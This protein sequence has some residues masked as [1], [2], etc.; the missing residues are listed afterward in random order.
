MEADGGRENAPFN[1]W[2][3][4]RIVYGR[5]HRAHAGQDGIGRAQPREAASH[6]RAG[7]YP[8]RTALY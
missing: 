5:T 3:P 7:P 6:A 1:S 4:E 8:S 2:L